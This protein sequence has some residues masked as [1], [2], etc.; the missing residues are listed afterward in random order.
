MKNLN[1]QELTYKIQLNKKT[2]LT[3]N[4]KFFQKEQISEKEMQ[5]N[6][7]WIINDGLF[8]YNCVI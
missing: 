3:E 1:R 5:T 7:T 2:L 4:D 8:F 6:N